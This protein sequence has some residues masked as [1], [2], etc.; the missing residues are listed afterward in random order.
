MHQSEQETM[1]VTYKNP[2]TTCISN[3]LSYQP[4]ALKAAIERNSRVRFLLSSAAEAINVSSPL[5][6]SL[7]Q[8]ISHVTCIACLVHLVND[9]T[10]QLAET[11]RQHIHEAEHE[12]QGKG[13]KNHVEVG[14]GPFL[15]SL[16]MG[17]GRD[18]FCCMSP[19]EVPRAAWVLHHGTF[20]F[21]FF[22]SPRKW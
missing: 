17:A 21:V 4:K 9:S 5:S 8:L 20:G 12:G 19:Q 16:K 13:Q 6:L 10:P 15:P 7:S 22:I 2:K 1:V 18:F 11:G 14:G 3:Q